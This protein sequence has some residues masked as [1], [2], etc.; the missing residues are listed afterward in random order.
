MRTKKLCHQIFDKKVKVCHK[1]NRCIMLNCRS[2]YEH[3]CKMLKYIIHLH[4]ISCI[5]LMH[6]VWPAVFLLSYLNRINIKQNKDVETSN[7]LDLPP[8]KPFVDLTV[9]DISRQGTWANTRLTSTLYD[10]VL[11]IL[12]NVPLKY[13]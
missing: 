6:N 12:Q 5:T 3:T 10:T 9:A 11:K 8:T 13:W 4:A 2:Y 7:F 1:N